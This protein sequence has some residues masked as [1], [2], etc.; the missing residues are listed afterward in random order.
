MAKVEFETKS[1][2]ARMAEQGALVRTSKLDRHHRDTQRGVYGRNIEEVTAE[3][4]ARACSIQ[5]SIAAIRDRLVRRILLENPDYEGKVSW[6]IKDEVAYEDALFA[7]APAAAALLQIAA[8]EQSGAPTAPAAQPAT[9]SSSLAGPGHATA[10]Q[11]DSP[12]SSDSI[13]G[14]VAYLRRTTA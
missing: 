7:G 14:S 4:Q 5:G 2:R 11:V 1:L 8:A 13:I 9:V 3:L 6:S 10:E 12:I